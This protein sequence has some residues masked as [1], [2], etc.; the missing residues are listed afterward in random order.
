MSIFCNKKTSHCC[1]KSGRGTFGALRL[2]LLAVKAPRRGQLSAAS[3]SRRQLVA[4]LP[5]E[6]A[7]VAR[8]VLVRRLAC[9]AVIDGFADLFAHGKCTPCIRVVAD[10]SDS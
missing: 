2:Y 1:E 10:G 3:V 5:S 9:L 4:R 7:L 8:G 6:R